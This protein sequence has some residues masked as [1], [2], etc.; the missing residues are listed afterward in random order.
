M[1]RE[2]RVFQSH[3]EVAHVWASRSQ[4]EG[5][6]KN[7]FFMNDTIYSYGTHFPIAK[8]VDLPNGRTIVLFNASDYSVSTSK[9]KGHVA[10][11]LNGLNVPVFR[12]PAKLWSCW[13]SCIES[14]K[15]TIADT[16]DKASRAREHAFGLCKWAYR[17]IKELKAFS[18][19]VGSSATYDFTEKDIKTI[20]RAIGYKRT[21]AQRSIESEKRKQAKLEKE[22]QE[23]QIACGGNVVVYWHKHGTLP[24]GYSAY[25]HL[26]YTCCRIVSDEIVTSRGARVPLE[27][28]KKLIPIIKR[29]KERSVTENDLHVKIGFY[30]LTDIWAN[31]DIQVGCHY[32]PFS[33]IEYIDNQITES[34][35]I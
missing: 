1:K 12:I 8:F 14:Y 32:I 6:A 26:P 15:H 23:L 34:V 16:F 33:E 28:A 24:Q 17:T 13:D 19:I 5:R 27:R 31:G 2:K 11:A 25:Y 35:L 7:V 30:T 9:H 10:G 21:G 4:S 3:S 22:K 29:Q 18:D 20:K